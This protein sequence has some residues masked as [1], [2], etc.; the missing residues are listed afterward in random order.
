MLWLPSTETRSSQRMI[1]R[2]ETAILGGCGRVAITSHQLSLP[3]RVA[4]KSD[5]IGPTAA[6]ANLRGDTKEPQSDTVLSEI[7]TKIPQALFA[8]AATRETNFT[9]SLRFMSRKCS[10][11]CEDA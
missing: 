10:M 2:F 6:I 1:Q 7:D 9:L 3:V 8:R 4:K 11:P 5:C